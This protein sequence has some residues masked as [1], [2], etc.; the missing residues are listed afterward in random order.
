MST[1]QAIVVKA[2]PVSN[3]AKRAPAM[4]VSSR[5][6]RCRAQL[7]TWFWGRVAIA[8]TA[9]IG[10]GVLMIVYSATAYETL[11]STTGFF[12]SLAIAYQQQVHDSYD[13][14]IDTRKPKDS[15][16]VEE[17]RNV[18][19]VANVQDIENGR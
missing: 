12:V 14:Y 6:L 19:E 13:S 10:L 4:N 11:F 1:E 8:I 3:S 7:L 9:G 17:V 16:K 18:V 5:L 2:E 15:S